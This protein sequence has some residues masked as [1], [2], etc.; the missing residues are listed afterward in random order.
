MYDIKEKLFIII[1]I[2]LSSG[3][4]IAIAY[5]I[6][7]MNNFK[8]G[9]MGG[10]YYIWF[11]L[12]LGLF[13][14]IAL[15]I[16]IPHSLIFISKHILIVIIVFLISLIIHWRSFNSGGFGG[17]YYVPADKDFKSLSN[18]ELYT[19]VFNKNNVLR[20]ESLKELE[21]RG[22]ELNDLLLNIINEQKL[23]FP[24]KY[25]DTYLVE[26]IVEIL[27]KR[28]VSA[29][30]PVLKDMLNSQLTNIITYDSEKNKIK[31]YPNRI[32]AIK[33]LEIYFNIQTSNIVTEK[34]L[35]E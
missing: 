30:I 20:D 28:K 8:I 9:D 18:D 6:A 31:K 11:S 27:S 22:P 10:Y 35:N 14:C 2:I 15:E 17:W 13:L 34:I 4:S 33:N 16:I 19:F 32:R 12:F 29:V 24:D 5:C 23:K 26:K 21:N 25:Y 7:R 3:I 1:T